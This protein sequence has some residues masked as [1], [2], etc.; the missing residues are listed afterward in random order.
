MNETA[1]AVII[2]GGVIGTSI[3]YHLARRQFGEIILLERNSLGSGSTGLSV[4][5]ID[6]LTMQEKAVEL[7]AQS[8][9]FFQ[10]SEEIL[11]AACGFVETGSLI[12]GGP[13]HETQLLAAV[14][15]MRASKVDVSV[16]TMHE[17][18]VWEPRMAVDGVSIATY[19]PHAGY[20]DPV[21]TTN[22]FAHAAQSL[23][24]DIQLGR[25]ATSLRFRSGQITGV[26]T[27]AGA[28]DAP[29]I[30]VAAG[31]WSGGLL[32]S[33]GLNLPL[34]VVSHPVV[35]L[36]RTPTFGPAHCALLDLTT[37]IYARPETGDLT[38]LGSLDPHIGH[39]PSDPN[40]GTGYVEDAYIYWAME[41]F[42]RRFPTLASGEINKG[43]SGFMTV[44]P[45]W[46]PVIGP[47]PEWQGLFCAVGFSGLGFQISP[48]TGDWLAELITGGK[49]ASKRLAPFSPAR[50]SEGQL[51]QTYREDFM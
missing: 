37:G 39:N 31:P 48:A 41:R 12:L 51:L 43:W 35:S 18:K 7:Y 38:L 29:I 28:I 21:L 6:S 30:I 45:D 40:R 15:F 10:H 1:D 34:T 22:T 25:G 9:A 32:R 11:G 17:L 23:G 13:A 44:S 5:T 26:N 4:A 20:A 2:G 8:A 33:V 14:Q 46:Q 47:C 16:L 3:A 49:E 42:T 19:A 24:V 36:R 27:S 50:F